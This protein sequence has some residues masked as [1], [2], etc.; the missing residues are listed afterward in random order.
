VLR[1]RIIRVQRTRRQHDSRQNAL[2]LHND[3]LLHPAAYGRGS[4]CGRGTH[5][6]VRHDLS[7]YI[8]I[9]WLTLQSGEQQECQSSVAYI[10][11]NLGRTTDSRGEE[12][13][14]PSN[15]LEKPT[16]GYRGFRDVT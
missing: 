16:A 11:E 8:D 1:Q 10:R 2:L 14:C 15:V 12:R 4:A 5:A 9:R 7:N 3:S 13:N 6:A